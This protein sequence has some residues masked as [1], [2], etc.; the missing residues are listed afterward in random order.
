MAVPQTDIDRRR[1]KTSI[2]CDQWR[3]VVIEVDG[4]HTA[5]AARLPCEQWRL[6]AVYGGKP[7]SNSQDMWRNVAI[8]GRRPCGNRTGTASWRGRPCS[9]RTVTAS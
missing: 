8:D 6:V 4:G 2:A 7:H 1:N 5:I 9:N 3:L